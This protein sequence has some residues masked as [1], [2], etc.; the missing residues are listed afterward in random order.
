MRKYLILAGLLAV[1]GWGCAPPTVA[2]SPPASAT[3]QVLKADWSDARP[4]AVPDVTG[5]SLPIATQAIAQADLH[6]RSEASASSQPLGTVL[7]Q[8]PRAGTMVSPRSS[9]TLDYS[10][11][12]SRTRQVQ[13]GCVVMIETNGHVN[14]TYSQS[15]QTSVPGGIWIAFG[16]VL[17]IIVLGSY[18]R[19]DRHRHR[20]S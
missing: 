6:C 3:P 15:I 13:N 8:D 12:K 11:R 18:R 4:V 17:L 2:G 20:A 1:V 14:V 7:G 9:V 10:G 16:L 5:Q 19:S